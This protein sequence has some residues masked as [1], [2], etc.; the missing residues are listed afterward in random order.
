MFGSGLGRM[1]LHRCTTLHNDT[2]RVSST[3]RW[4]RHTVFFLLFFYLLVSPLRND[5]VMV[6]YTPLKDL[7]FHTPKPLSKPSSKPMSKSL[8]VHTLCLMWYMWVCLH[9]VGAAADPFGERGWG[10][11]A[12]GWPSLEV[13]G[14]NT[15]ART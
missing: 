1:S 6:M 7:H 11:Y 14:K 2:I 8:Y 9:V 15:V 13:C 10:Q 4:D 3:Q 12:A 5:R